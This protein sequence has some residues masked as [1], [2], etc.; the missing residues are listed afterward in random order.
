MQVRTGEQHTFP[1]GD[2]TTRQYVVDA[3][4]TMDHAARAL[5]EAQA[6]YFA[7]N[8]DAKRWAT[9]LLWNIEPD[10]GPDNHHNKE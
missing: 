9:S 5:H 1:I 4:P 3:I 2:A 8:P 10:A 7:A 6:R